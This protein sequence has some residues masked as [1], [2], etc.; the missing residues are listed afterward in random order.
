MSEIPEQMQ[1][2]LSWIKDPDL[3]SKTQK[4]LEEYWSVFSNIP[5]SKSGRWHHPSENFKPYGL[6]NHTLRCLRIAEMMCEQMALGRD[7]SDLVF[8]ALVLHDVGK[9]K[10]YDPATNKSVHVD[11]AEWAA[12]RAANEG[13][14]TAVVNMI[15]RHSSHWEGSNIPTN[16]LEW[17]VSYADYISS[18]ET[19]EIKDCPM[20]RPDE[21]K[22]EPTAEGQIVNPLEHYCSINEQI[23]ELE[24]KKEKTREVIM[25]IFVDKSKSVLIGKYVANLNERSRTDID[26]ALLKTLL[27]EEQFEK[28]A[29]KSTSVALFVKKVE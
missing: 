18:R 2:L 6:I 12:T 15:L 8:T 27:G 3:R 28:V 4:I 9:I 20:F 11:H 14:P 29:K 10:F 5:S 26:Q 1:A 23:R 22:L 17:I 7:V 13:L 24:K 21:T 16:E 19:I 25:K